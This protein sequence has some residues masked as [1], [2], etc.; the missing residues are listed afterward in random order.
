MKF[1]RTIIVYSAIAFA[2]AF[3]A[4][5]PSAFAKS[6]QAILTVTGLPPSA[7]YQQLGITAGT[8]GGSGT[9]AVSYNAGN[10]TA[11]SINSSTGAVTITSGTGTCSITATKAADT[12]YNS[13]TSA[14]VSI[15]IGK[16]NQA[17]LTVSGLPSS[18]VYQQSGVIAGTSGGSGTGSVT[19][20]ANS[21]TACSVGSSSGTVTI[22]SGS[23]TCSITATKA[24]DTNYNSAT[25]VAVSITVSYID[26]TAGTI[27]TSPT[28]VAVGSSV[29]LTAPVTN[30]GTAS[31]GGSFTDLFEINQNQ[32]PADFASIYAT[33]PYTSATLAANGDT[34]TASASYTFASNGTWYVRACADMGTSGTGS[35]NEWNSGGTGEL[36]NCGGWTTFTVNNPVPTTT[37]ISPTSKTAGSSGFTLTVNG[38]NFNSSS[39]VNFAGSPRATTYVS[40]TQLTASISSSDI[41]TA[42]TF[43]VTVTNPSP[44]GGTSGS[45]TFT[46]N[47]PAPT[48]S[49]ISPTSKVAGSSGFTL[50]VNGTNF[51]SSSVV[52][53]TGSARTTTYVSATQLTAAI[54]SSDAT[55]AGTFAITVTNPTPGG[56]TSLSQTFTVTAPDLIITGTIT[57]TG[58]TAGTSV[59]LTAT[60]TNQGNV[61]TGASFNTLFQQATDAN[62]A[63]ATKLGTSTGSTLS[64]TA[65]SNT[66]STTLPYTFTTAGT[67]YVRACANT[68]DNVTF[69]VAESNYGN[70]CG[71]WT[72]ITVNPGA[73]DHF[74]IGAISVQVAGTP[75]S[76]T[77]TAQDANNNTVTSSASTV[78]LTSNAGTV[79]PATTGTFTSGKWTGTVSLTQANNAAIITATNGKIGTSNAFIISASPVSTVTISPATL[80]VALGSSAQ[81]TATAK[82]QYGN[83]RTGDSFSWSVSSGGGSVSSSGLY[84]PDGQV[85]TFTVTATDGA[86]SGTATVTVTAPD[87]TASGVT[88]TTVAAG[89]AQL[90]STTV[91]N[92]G[93]ASTGANFN[94]LFQT[95]ANANGT[96]SADIGS[97]SS[98][99]LAGGATKT[100]SFSYTTTKAGTF[101]IRA[102]ADKSSASDTGLITESNENNNCGVWTTITV[103]AGALDHFGIGAIGTQYVNIPFPISVT[104]QDA[105]NNTI[106]NYAGTLNYT[107][108]VCNK[109][110]SPTSSGS[111]TNGVRTETVTISQASAGATITA[112]E[113]GGGNNHPASTSNNFPVLAVLFPTGTGNYQQWVTNTDG[114][115][116]AVA[117]NDGDTTYVYPQSLYSVIDQLSLSGTN[118][119]D[120]SGAIA[121]SQ[122]EFQRIWQ[123]D[124]S[125]LAG[126]SPKQRTLVL[127]TPRGNLSGNSNSQAIVDAATCVKTLDPGACSRA[128]ITLDSSNATTTI[129]VMSWGATG[130]QSFNDS[131]S[132]GPGY[133]FYAPN[134]DDVISVFNQIGQAICPATV[135]SD[136]GAAGGPTGASLQVF[137]HVVNNDGG[138]LSASNFPFTVNSGAPTPGAEPPTGVTL[139]WSD[140][141]APYAVAQ[142]QVAGY[143]APDIGPGCTS[144]DAGM[145]ILGETRMCVLTNDDTAVAPTIT[146]GNGTW[147]EVPTY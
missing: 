54:S 58:A 62:G 1:P 142:S 31:T 133:S 134:S 117:G 4:G 25:S 102:C 59:T 3:F 108:S 50:T 10:S 56:G 46:V 86:I 112:T 15:T 35:I 30:S 7:V 98:T 5:A 60:I 127:V 113:S 11:C 77:I 66:E 100:V 92:I 145:L 28:S 87:L 104:A 132:S 42:D 18:A 45:Q 124:K 90:Y 84:A 140:L 37:S 52:N 17:T 106:L 115:V 79:S 33:Q 76:I 55:T 61:S 125:I 47:N 70:N 130:G 53:F 119:K 83:T 65:G 139:A 39:V 27:T 138:K 73:L 2:L 63:G 23:G 135:A 75:F 111:F 95:A 88:P 74:G 51:N 141:T 109:C 49:S 101:Y 123:V 20:S 93:N 82:D 78:A 81:F 67:T 9:G 8:S 48:T 69:G 91:S 122:T 19:Y 146:V 110:I 128:G 129:Y 85:G 57:P 43:N 40:A 68:T 26:L 97:V 80:S 14:A 144:S 143:G 29:T 6:T 21:S 38:T 64:S 103:S 136:S 107:T 41:A 16:A 94:T 32:N 126:A 121:A 118:G 36:N 147:Q 24:S 12:N 44:G 120:V 99:A 96:G 89:T 13:A 114:A 137:T 72:P 131:L 22:T 116:N 105:Y 71:A 34:N